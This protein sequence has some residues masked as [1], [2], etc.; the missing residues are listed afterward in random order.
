MVLRKLSQ[1]NEAVILL[2][3][4]VFML[5]MLLLAFLIFGV[6]ILMYGEWLIVGIVVIAVALIIAN[7]F[8][9]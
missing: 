5:V 6:F 7:R 1:N 8:K 3:I 9:K 4:G 2:I